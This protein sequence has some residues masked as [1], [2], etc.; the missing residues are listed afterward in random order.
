MKNEIDLA[1]IERFADVFLNKFESRVISKM[2]E[3]L[4]PPGE[5]VVDNHDAPAFANQGIAQMGAE[6]PGASKDDYLHGARGWVHYLAIQA[7]F[8]AS[9]GRPPLMSEKC[10]L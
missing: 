2:G 6:K 8:R 5:Q 10:C 9:P 3:I 1:C 4:K 7:A